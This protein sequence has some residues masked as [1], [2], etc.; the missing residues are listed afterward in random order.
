MIMMIPRFELNHGHLIC[1][2]VCC[3]SDLGMLRMTLIVPIGGTILHSNHC[4]KTSILG[5]M[6]RRL[7]KAIRISY[8]ISYRK[9][10]IR[11]ITPAPGIMFITACYGVHCVVM[12]GVC[13]YV[14]KTT[15]AYPERKP[16]ENTH[17]NLCLGPELIGIGRLYGIHHWGRLLDT[18]RFLL[19]HE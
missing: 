19:M 8:L 10:R 6:L 15:Q 12:Y 4:P 1:P 18:D 5:V 17:F 11:K 2:F 16:R 9:C 14:R 7:D 3:S 13:G